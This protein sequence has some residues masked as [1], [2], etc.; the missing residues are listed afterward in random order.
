MK[1]K[2]KIKNKEI[3]I[4]VL[5][6]IIFLSF[7][8]LGTTVLGS[9]MFVRSR[10][11]LKNNSLSTKLEAYN[12]ENDFEDFSEKFDDEYNNVLFCGIDLFNNTDVIMIISINKKLHTVNVLR[13]PRDTY[14]GEEYKT[15]KINAVY[16]SPKPS[17]TGADTLTYE[18][19]NIFR[20]KIDK[21]IFMTLDIFEEMIDDIGGVEIYLENDLKI[22]G[23]NI[24]KAGKINLDGKQGAN[25]V[26]HRKTYLTGDIGRIHAQEKFVKALGKKLVEDKYL[27]NIS[28]LNKYYNKI[29]TNIG[30][31]EVNQYTEA[32]KDIDIN[33]MKTF[34]LSGVPVIHNKYSVYVIDKNKA[35]NL[36]NKYFMPTGSKLNPEDIK[37]VKYL[38]PDQVPVETEYF[39]INSDSYS[40]Q[41]NYYNNN[42]FTESRNLNSYLD[43]LDNNINSQEYEIYEDRYIDDDEEG[44]YDEDYDDYDDELYSEINELE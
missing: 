13:I 33:K 16:S 2:I 10:G 22:D 25:F 44:D 14:I 39:D 42:Y 8:L 23:G 21:Y 37:L 19:N 29:E 32:I 20:I 3:N 15:G 26:R 7:I 41:S 24:I 36:L 6:L 43:S 31:K 11:Q 28:F 12:I 34:V 1:I 4:F 9:Y 27:S 40:D 35:V 17:L 18:I 30:R 38:E 5:I